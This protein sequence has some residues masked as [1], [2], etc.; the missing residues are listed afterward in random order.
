MFRISSFI[1]KRAFRNFSTATQSTGNPTI[2]PTKKALM[3][4]RKITGYNYVNCKKALDK[5]GPD[6]IEEATAWL[7]ELAKKEGWA[8][9][10]KLSSKQTAEGLLS[11]ITK[12]NVGAVVELNCQTDFV[13][14]GEVFKNLIE[15]ISEAVLNHAKVISST[16][17]VPKN[18]IVTVPVVTDEIK[19]NDG[20]SITE[21]IA[22]TV[23]K[24]GENITSPVM[25]M[26]FAESD[27]SLKGHSHPKEKIN[28]CEVGRFVSVIG[29]KRDAAKSSSFPSEKLGE[30]ICQHI[31][32][33]RP[34]S[35]GEPPV[36]NIETKEETKVE[37]KDNEEEDEANSFYSG[38]TTDL[39]EDETSLLR[40]PFMLNPS[41]SVYSYLEGH[42]AQVVN[43]LRMEV[44]DKSSE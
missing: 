36:E 23:G 3:K 20:I 43:Y 44:G 12:G 35:L 27:V 15:K 25:N 10:A 7:R 38:K 11:V 18:Q 5:F 32:G 28:N 22:M 39:N 1:G 29:L 24:L 41:Q 37:K 9:A 31:I 6:N 26:I 13:A 2:T 21:A 34:E 33:M 30:Q 8:K 40:Q 16:V 14:R 19:T 42:G 17:N 4:L